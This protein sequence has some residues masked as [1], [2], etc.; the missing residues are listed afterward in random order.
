[1]KQYL[2]QSREGPKY[3]SRDIKAPTARSMSGNRR[4]DYCYLANENTR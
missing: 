1:L 2:Q 4:E 3:I